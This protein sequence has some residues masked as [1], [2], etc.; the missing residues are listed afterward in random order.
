MR[1]ISRT[2]TFKSLPMDEMKSNLFSSD[3]IFL[4]QF[5]RT[6][7]YSMDQAFQVLENHLLFRK[8]QPEWFDW[9]DERVKQMKKLYQNGFAYPL[10]ERDAEGRRLLMINQSRLDPDTFNSEDAFHLFF[11]VL[12]TLLCEEETQVS[13]VSIIAS[14]ENVTLKYVSLYSISEFSNIT[15]FLKNSCPG[16]TKAF[17]LINLPLFAEFLINAMKAAMTPKLKS[18]LIAVKGI[19]ELNQ[20]LDKSLLPREFGGANLTEAEMM[21]TFMESFEANLNF[22]RRTNEFSI[23]SSKL[24][25]CDELQGNIGSFRKLEID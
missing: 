12:F 20:F 25:G 9:S 22:L 15:K 4:L 13:G 8:S 17:Y 19:N 7:K 18:R 10:M 11:M 21:E 1:I 5:L 6:K 24:M 23:D 3:D 16:R 2:K 14:Y